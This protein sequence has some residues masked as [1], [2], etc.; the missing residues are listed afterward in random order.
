MQLIICPQ[1]C[2]SRVDLSLSTGL[3]H[4]QDDHVDVG[5]TPQIEVRDPSHETSSLL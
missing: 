2:I 4:S 3:I 1:I 5:K